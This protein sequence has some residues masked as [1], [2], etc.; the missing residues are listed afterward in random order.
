MTACVPLFDS[1][2]TLNVDVCVRAP[3]T[4]SHNITDRQRASISNGRAG[5]ALAPMGDCVDSEWEMPRT[6]STCCPWPFFFPPAAARSV[7]RYTC[8]VVVGG[9]DAIGSVE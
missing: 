7:P 8:R 9:D 3:H 4:T 2:D 6:K 1:H 5:L